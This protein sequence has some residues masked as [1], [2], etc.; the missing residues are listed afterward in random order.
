MTWSDFC[1]F[2]SPF[3]SMQESEFFQ[4]KNL[5]LHVT[6]KNFSTHFS[7]VAEFN[8]IINLLERFQ[9]FY[10]YLTSSVYSVLKWAAGIR[11]AFNKFQSFLLKASNSTDCSNRTSMN[12]FTMDLNHCEIPSFLDESQYR[13]TTNGHE[14]SEYKRR[15][16]FPLK[17]TS[18]GFVRFLYLF[19]EF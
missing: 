1:F 12:I 14:S 11:E 7:G 5:D 4:H 10:H 18:N 2:N 3:F 16:R 13:H 9:D 17:K 15:R 8:K 6:K 19:T